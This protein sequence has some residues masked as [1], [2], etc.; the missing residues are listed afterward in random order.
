MD[1][2]RDDE[3]LFRERSLDATLG[4]QR[5]KIRDAVASLSKDDL[6]QTPRDD[7]S[8][9]VAEGF[10]VTPLELDES[11]ASVDQDE[12]AIPVDRFRDGRFRFGEDPYNQARTVPGHE[13]R[14]Y[15]PFS[16]NPQ[17]FRLRPNQW[18]SNAPRGQ[19]ERNELVFSFKTAAVG[20]HVKEAY[21]QKL[22]GVRR[23]VDS[24]RSLVED[25][26]ARVEGLVAQLLSQ[27]FDRI[28]EATR[29]SESLG[30]PL[31]RREGTIRTYAAP[32]V[33]RKLRS[34]SAHTPHS[35]SQPS[36]APEPAVPDTEY[37]HILQVMRNMAVVLERSPSAFEAI[38]E[39][40]I[41]W[42]FLVQLNGQYE[43]QATGETFN[44]TGKTDILVRS[45]ERNIFIAEC[46]FW[47]G[48]K[49]LTA[50]ID[51]LLGY[52]TWRD[53]KAAIIIFNREAKLT[54]VL[55]KIPGTMKDHPSCS[56]EVRRV[57]ETT[58][59]TTLAHI[60]D[61]ERKI[62]VTVMVFDVPKKRR[63]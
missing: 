5:E 47:S 51:Q 33:R 4:A 10:L 48:P 7:L 2:I 21:E 30:V 13:V 31:R 11:N 32:E 8:R 42:H 44:Y 27:R 6:L 1:V 29:A 24:Q 35:P 57:D 28:Q 40:G 25:H 18:S 41:R 53:T 16:G 17:L 23:E 3:A 50:T 14:Y 63:T 52:L 9:R 58:F 49:R 45:G 19:V 34:R 56:A 38:G 39:E 55:E 12:F 36:H 60:D 26:N 59:V 54:T 22:R 20:P 15:V 37:E 43:G 61:P 62:R 46:K